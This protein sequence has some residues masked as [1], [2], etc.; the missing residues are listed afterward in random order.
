M[1]R[2][3]A[4]GEKMLSHSE[5]HRRREAPGTPAD[6]VQAWTSPRAPSG[7]S[8]SLYVEHLEAHD[9]STASP[10]LFPVA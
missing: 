9:V 5:H 4:E 6:S 8:C 3:M 7:R 10:V 1:L 2:A